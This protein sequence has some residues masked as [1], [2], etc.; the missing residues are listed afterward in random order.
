MARLGAAFKPEGVVSSEIGALARSEGDV[1]DQILYVK[2]RGQLLLMHSFQSFFIQTLNLATK[3]ILENGRPEQQQYMVALL[4][5]FG[6]FRR[7][8]ACEILFESGYPLDGLAHIRDVKDRAFLLCAIARNRLTFV[9]A[10]GGKEGLLVEEDYADV[11]RGNRMKVSSRVSQELMGKSSGLS[12]ANQKL[13]KRWDNLFH[14]E[15]HNGLLSFGQEMLALLNERKAPSIGPTW[16]PYAYA[17]FVNRTS[18]IG[19]ML[20]RLFPFIQPLPHAFGSD[21]SKKRMVLDDSFRF[22]VE[23]YGK[24]GNTIS[25]AFI[26]M[27]DKKFKFKESFCY[28]DSTYKP[29]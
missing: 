25:E 10:F 16:E 8:R 11:T 22:L 12:E 2:H 20:A 28:S 13:L 4:H 29:A 21:W 6:L 3:H 14:L 26:T 5:F 7:F 27:M 23:M 24:N 19:W 18:E 9:E 17:A 15:V 1:A